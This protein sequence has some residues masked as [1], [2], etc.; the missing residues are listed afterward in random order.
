M[1]K[2]LPIFYNTLLL[3]AVNLALRFV[4]TSFQVYLS[5]KIG[6]AG[7]G[8]LQLVLSVGGLAM[9]V[10]MGGIR[11]ATMY[12][13]AE[14]VGQKRTD[15]MGWVLSGCIRYSLL[16]SIFTGTLLYALA[17]QI[18]AKWIGNPDTLGAIRL[19]GCFLPIN[20]LCGVM[21]GH[22]T[23]V[24]RI[25]TLA[26]VEV[27]EQFFTMAVTILLISV[28]AD[29]D[30]SRTCQAVILGGGFGACFTVL[31][32]LLLKRKE[33]NSIGK[34]ISIRHKLF[35]T[36]VPLAIADNV[37]AGINTT[38]SLL[39]PKRLALFPGE[40]E[41][42][43]SF[44]MVCGMVFPVLML[45]AAILFALADLLIPELARCNA[46]GS[47]LR[48]RHLTERSLLLALIYGA[49]CGGILFLRADDLCFA[50]YKTT[51][52][53]NYLKWYAVLA[54]MLYCDT[55]IDAIT[56]GLGQ[57]QICVRNNIITSA[58]DV[59]L[60][61]IL[62]PKYGMVGYYFS[63]LI[64]HLINLILS[65]LLLIK[66]AGTIITLHRAVF[67]ILAVTCAM[68]VGVSLP[69]NYQ[70]LGFCSVFTGLLM[71]FN[72]IKKEDFMWLKGV[73]ISK[74]QLQILHR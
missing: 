20:C 12:L 19:L 34:R 15:A 60:L 67:S 58:M 68:L 10:G 30:P 46:A 53:G 39:V 40:S 1:A 41:P 74:H 4:S 66:L 42:L 25:G 24:N 32:L 5:G 59:I 52:A 69:N 11:T 21:V 14:T 29:Q 18:A 48:I 70:V 56:K 57:Q 44:G 64:T 9:T 73:L 72:V 43:A 17:P 26:V 7:I 37:K 16:L 3:T 28:W 27:A 45:P 33:H 36:A 54:P 6:A 38:E 49:F 50:L 51:D 13:C 35:K 61:F 2:K 23:G 8:L 65:T 22:F 55:I 63:F 47:K 62:L 31:L 71:L